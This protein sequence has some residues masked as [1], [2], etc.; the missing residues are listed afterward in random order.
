MFISFYIKATIWQSRILLFHLLTKQPIEPFIASY[1]EQ[2]GNETNKRKTSKQTTQ[3]SFAPSLN[4]SLPLFP[5]FFI[6]ICLSVLFTPFYFLFSF[7][8]FFFFYIFF[9]PLFCFLFLDIF[10]FP[11]HRL[12]Q[13]FKNK[14]K[15]IGANLL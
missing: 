11:E 5:V 7:F 14:I 10:S 1:G 6:S 3:I 8:L 15:V 4:A 9:F 2:P 12:T 13:I